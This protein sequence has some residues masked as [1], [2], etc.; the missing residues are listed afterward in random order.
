VRPALG[1]DA[2]EHRAQVVRTPSG[3]INRSSWGCSLLVFRKTC[4][5]SR[6]KGLSVDANGGIV[7]G[8]NLA[9]PLQHRRQFAPQPACSGGSRDPQFREQIGISGPTDVFTDPVIVGAAV[10]LMELYSC[11]FRRK[12]ARRNQRSRIQERPAISMVLLHTQSSRMSS[13]AAGLST[14]R[15]QHIGRS[16]GQRSGHPPRPAAYPHGEK[17]R[18]IS[19]QRE[20]GRLAAE[21]FHD[22]AR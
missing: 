14:Q 13:N 20:I 7:P 10:R 16:E 21:R 1:R 12:V 3:Q 19:S 15:P 18:P 6:W 17:N 5:I 22:V 4:M 2:R 9:G 11:S 8:G